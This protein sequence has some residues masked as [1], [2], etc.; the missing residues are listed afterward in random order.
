[1]FACILVN[2][3]HLVWGVFW[4]NVCLGWRGFG[5]FV[6]FTIGVTVNC[7]FMVSILRLFCLTFGKGGL[8]GQ[9]P[10]VWGYDVPGSYRSTITVEGQ[11]SGG[12]F[13]VGGHEWCRQVRVVFIATRPFG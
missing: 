8:G 13:V 7:Y 11:I 1:M 5:G 2:G 10:V 9:F 6:T 12:G 4:G 3:Y